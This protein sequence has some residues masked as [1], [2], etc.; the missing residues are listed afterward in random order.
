VTLQIGPVPATTEKDHQK[1]NIAIQQ[2]FRAVNGIQTDISTGFP[3][4]LDASIRLSSNNTAKQYQVS[5]Y[6]GGNGLWVY[7][8]SRKQFELTPINGA[9]QVIDTTSCTINGV[10]NQAMANSTLYYAYAVEASTLGGFVNI[11]HSTTGPVGGDPAGATVVLG[12]QFKND[13]TRNQ[14]L[15]GAINTDSSGKIWTA[16]S[17][18][19]NFAGI[20]SY[21]QRQRLN[22][23]IQVAA[24]PFTSASFAEINST[25]RITAFLWGDGAEPS[26][27]LSG[28]VQHSVGGVVVSVGVGIDV[29]APVNYDYQDIYCAVAS[30]P[31]PFCVNVS[32]GGYANG[33]HSFGIWGKVPSGTGSVNIGNLTLNLNQ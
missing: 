14:R 18:G 20:G 4:S 1:I 11:D 8:P 19:V 15:I 7:S 5:Y 25:N 16:G 23:Q 30:Q 2:L 33:N 27:Q 26:C 6:G 9:F 13:G 31:Y 22:Y 24:Q 21:Y 12:W 32:S 3:V 28:T 29:A 17:H 10:A